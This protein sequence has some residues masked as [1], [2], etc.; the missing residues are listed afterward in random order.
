MDLTFWMNIEG[1]GE[2]PEQII[3]N[4]NPENFNVIYDG[5]SLFHHFAGNQPVI[6]A[7]HEAYMSAKQDGLL[8]PE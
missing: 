3:E 7:I 6:E 1:L 4:T 2:D 5:S 8:T